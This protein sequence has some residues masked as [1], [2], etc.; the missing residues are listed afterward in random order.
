MAPHPPQSLD[1]PFDLPFVII[2]SEPRPFAHNQDSIGMT[3]P[4]RW[5]GFYLFVKGQVM[6]PNHDVRIPGQEPIGADLK[7]VG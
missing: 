3:A 1:C 2:V 4:F 7:G 5:P 6:G